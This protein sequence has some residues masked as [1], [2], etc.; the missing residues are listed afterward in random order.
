MLPPV[1]LMQRLTSSHSESSLWLARE[2][3]G[4]EIPKDL[5]LE[6]IVWHFFLPRVPLQGPP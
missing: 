1:V 6:I 4:Q 5:L 2:P 3:P